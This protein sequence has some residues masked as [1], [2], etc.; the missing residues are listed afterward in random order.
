MKKYRL[1]VHKQST[2]EK[3]NTLPVDFYS[4]HCPGSNIEG[5]AV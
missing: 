1:A 5:L 4:S 3:C 2:Y